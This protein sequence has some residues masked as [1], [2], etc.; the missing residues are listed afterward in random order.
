MSNCVGCSTFTRPQFRNIRPLTQIR[1]VVTFGWREY[2]ACPRIGCIVLIT[3]SSCDINLSLVGHTSVFMSSGEHWGQSP[4]FPGFPAHQLNAVEGFIIE[5]SSSQKAVH[6]RKENG[7]SI[8]LLQRHRRKTLPPIL[9]QALLVKQSN[10]TINRKAAYVMVE[11]LNTSQDLCK[12]CPEPS[13]PQANISSSEAAAPKS[14]RTS[15][16]GGI[17]VTSPL[18]RSSLKT[19]FVRH[20]QT[21]PRLAVFLV[22]K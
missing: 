6:F 4:P 19:F 16:I 11:S 9:K 12:L 22:M 2:F 1:R 5:S 15:S 3:V 18:R 21:Q 10:H 13:P 8:S 20:I 14:A 17:S 7:T